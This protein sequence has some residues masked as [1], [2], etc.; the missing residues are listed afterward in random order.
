M[1]RSTHPHM[2]IVH[3]QLQLSSPVL[4]LGEPARVSVV[5]PRP[6]PA[7]APDRLCLACFTCHPLPY[8]CRV[9]DVPGF[10]VTKN[11]HTGRSTP[12]TP[13][14]SLSCMWTHLRGW[15][16]T[17]RAT[18]IIQVCQTM[19]TP[20]CPLGTSTFTSCSYQGFIICPPCLLT[21][22]TTAT[23]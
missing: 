11:A 13:K 14:C 15:V 1:V 2:R 4:R 21:K 19:L 3:A 23:E 20:G 5:T 8:P 12:T 7:E 17:R 6:C 16:L 22:N 9:R 10:N 18:C